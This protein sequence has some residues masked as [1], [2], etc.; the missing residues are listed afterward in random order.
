M[1]RQIDIAWREVVWTRQFELNAVYDLLTHLAATVP[2]G[3]VVWEI[4]GNCKKTQ[5][6][7]GVDRM[8]LKKI[9]DIFKAQ[10]DV[11]FLDLKADGRQPVVVAE[12]LKITKPVL[13][14]KTDMATAVIR[15]GLA[16]LSNI[17]EDGEAVV[18]V[19]LGPSFA[20]AP[21]PREMPNPHASWLQAALGNAGTASTESM[22]AIRDKVSQHG[23]NAVIR[24]GLTKETAANTFFSILSALKV[25]ETA[26]V[27]IT[28]TDDKANAINTAKVPWSFPLRLSIRE[29]ANFLLLP[30]GDE[31]FPGANGLHPKTILPP[32]WYKSPAS[33]NDRSFAV[34]TDTS[35]EIRLSVSPKDA[36]EHTVILGPTGSG[37][38]NVILNKALADIR[39]GRSVLVIDPKSDL[40]ND[41]L[42]RIEPERDGDVVVIDPSSPDPVGFNPFTKDYGTST[43]IAEAVLAVFQEVFKENWG[44]RSQDVFSH[45]FLT[46]AQTKGASLVWLPALLTNADFRRKIT[47]GLTDKIGLIPFW[48]EYEAMK[49][50]ERRTEIGPVQNK[51]RQFLL[52]PDLRN[53]LGQSNPKFNF[54]DLFNKRKIVLVPLNKG[55]I[56]SESAQLLGSL[57]VGILWKLALARADV[58]PEKRHMVSVFI[59]ELQDYLRLPTDLSEALAQARG[60]GLSLTLAHQY[61]EQLP[62][63][64]R[65]G[66]DT[67]CRNK[68]AFG[69]NIDDA[70]AMANMAS[71]LQ[72]ED[73]MKLP[74]YHIYTNFQSNG[75]STGWV[76]GQTLPPPPATRDIVDLRA[77][78]M[79][80]Y[81][82][83]A[84]TVEAEYLEM[85]EASRYQPPTDGRG[86]H[87]AGDIGRW[88]A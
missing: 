81:G 54:T 9:T 15:A 33:A 77:K 17:P 46:L 3:A 63:N 80:A 61:R 40:V 19:I 45:A 78:S 79:A 50:S 65:A 49:D 20:P 42:Q 37:K 52:R 48:E 7:L 83:S 88:K 76:S 39:A 73:F 8:Y 16:A 27:R 69:L 44:I 59:D 4:R 22:S 41:I 85:L 55:T 31:E 5:Y 51:V 62:P 47:A 24:I 28:T 58:E 86:N 75:R 35:R 87:D 14:L 30:V 6:L 67:N 2:R 84:E 32:A 21:A 26:G 56:G 57:I 68:I 60:L 29:L 12:Q 38:S 36:L 13:S 70:K 64:I 18:Q 1:K 66:V 71:E 53:V 74:R 82:Q 10:G 23:F 11:R 72:A 25:L 34:N 43:Q